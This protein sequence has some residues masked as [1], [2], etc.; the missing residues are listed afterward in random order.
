MFLDICG[1]SRGDAAP[2]D[3]NPCLRRFQR[4][5]MK[6]PG[7]TIVRSCIVTRGW[8]FPYLLYT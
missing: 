8:I 6:G 2:P 3:D 1:S 4:M 7:T 5:F